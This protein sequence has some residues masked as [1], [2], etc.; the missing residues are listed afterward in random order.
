MGGVNL[1][2]INCG[3]KQSEG[4]YCAACGTALG[5]DVIGAEL[6]RSKPIGKSDTQSNEYVEKVKMVSKMYWSYLLNYL[7]NP[8]D[9]L[10][11]E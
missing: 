5:N 8:S 6:T 7:K 10:K 3:H 11:Q 9:V 1:H 2:C 4:K